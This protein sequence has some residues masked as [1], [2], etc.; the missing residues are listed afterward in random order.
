M[1]IRV[2]RPGLR[3]TIQ[4]LGRGGLQ[5]YG[6]SVGG[7][8][9]SFA[10]RVAN[11]L[12]GNEENAA[13]LEMTLSG[14]ELDFERGAL[15]AICGGDWRPTIGGVAVP[16]WRPVLIVKGAVL[17]FHNAAAGCHAYLAV[18]GGFDVPVVLGSRSTYLRAG[19]GGLHGR[20]L[21]AGD[22]LH[23]RPRCTEADVTA[24]L[25]GP[26]LQP[27]QEPRAQGS[28]VAA[29]WFVG[30]D[31]AHDAE[32]PIVRVVRGS[33]FDWLTPESQSNFFT[34]EFQ[35][36]PQADRM[37]YR[38]AGPTLNLGSFHELLS[39]AVAAGTIQVPPNG[40]PIV[41][42][43]DRATTGGYAKVAHV[44]TVDL[45]VMAQARPGAKIRFRPISIEE[46]QV[47]YRAREAE[48]RKL[49]VALALRTA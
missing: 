37:G 20:A 4:D 32:H 24:M 1:S 26:W 14:P 2:R 29:R 34:A 31:L 18:A 9:D 39:E 40:Q 16:A 45:P 3:T 48:I 35:V 12:V 28:F 21:Q 22:V 13:A 43:A 23:V 41:L 36:T 19:I 6:V 10:I 38:M 30:V 7:A 42:M 8:M 33:E 11:L 25:A 44:A 27:P 15:I 49:K 5:Q 17:K 47:L 46:A